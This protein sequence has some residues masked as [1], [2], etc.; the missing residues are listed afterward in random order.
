M[1]LGEP[2]ESRSSWDYTAMVRW[3]LITSLV[4]ADDS[5]QKFAYLRVDMPAARDLV[6]DF[7]NSV[8]PV[9]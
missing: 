6:L 1:L 2:Y 5:I 4:R 7:E 3:H 8:S 9:R